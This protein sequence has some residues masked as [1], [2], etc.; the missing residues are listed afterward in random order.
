MD[1]LAEFMQ[2]IGLS[3]HAM[4]CVVLG[5]DGAFEVLVVED[6]IMDQENAAASVI[7]PCL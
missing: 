5:Q 6:D 3:N 7:L 4:S 2:Q 1:Q